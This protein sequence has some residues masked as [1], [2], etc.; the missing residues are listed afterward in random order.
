[1]WLI[2]CWFFGLKSVILHTL[3][4]LTLI[5][6]IC[7]YKIFGKTYTQPG[8]PAEQVVSIGRQLNVKERVRFVIMRAARQNR[9]TAV[10]TEV[11]SRIAVVNSMILIIS[12]T[13]LISNWPSVT[14][15]LEQVSIVHVFVSSLITWTSFVYPVSLIGESHSFALIERGSSFSIH[16]SRTREKAN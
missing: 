2:I 13:I 8:G 10:A 16:S 14:F 12:I 15:G 11:I 5:I 9:Q 3:V 4:A 6:S 1:M 7:C